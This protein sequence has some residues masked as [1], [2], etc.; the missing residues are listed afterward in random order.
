MCQVL[1]SA[2]GEHLE[3]V[4]AEDLLDPEKARALDVEVCE[5]P[6]QEHLGQEQAGGDRQEAQGGPLAGEDLDLARLGDLDPLGGGF[7]EFDRAVQQDAGAG[8]VGPV[9]R[10]VVCQSLIDG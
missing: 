7:G 3:N 9:V 6:A 1:A 2:K 4:D 10:V 8:L 5:Q